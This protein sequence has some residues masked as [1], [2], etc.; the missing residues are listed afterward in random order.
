[1]RVDRESFE[2]VRPHRVPVAA[3]FVLIALCACMRSVLELPAQ[4]PE[5][6]SVEYR[7]TA[8]L[9]GDVLG[10]TL[11]RDLPGAGEDEI[12]AVL[13]Y[14]RSEPGSSFELPPDP[15]GAGDI[16]DAPPA[17]QAKVDGNRVCLQAL[18]ASDSASDACLQ[19]WL[20]SERCY[21]LQP[22]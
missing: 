8:V 3:L 2:S 15:T 4:Q 14:K 22:E 9:S 20:G 7:F 21:D 18:G 19:S 1:M 11:S 13:T 10:I 16:E 17:L 12:T 5:T 6:C